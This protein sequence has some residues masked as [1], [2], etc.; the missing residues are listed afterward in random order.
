MYSLK[1][2]FD[3]LLLSLNISL[4]LYSVQWTVMASNINFGSFCSISLTAYCCKYLPPPLS[5]SNLPTELWSCV[6][7]QL[8]SLPKSIALPGDLCSAF[9]NGM[10][11]YCN[12]FYKYLPCF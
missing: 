8:C 5:V 9:V 6:A 2:C 4:V 1:L 12:A 10:L 11:K 7:R 3:F